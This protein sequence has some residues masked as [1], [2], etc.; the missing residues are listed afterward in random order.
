MAGNEANAR[1]HLRIHGRVQ[2]VAF[3]AY[4]IDEAVRLRVKGWVRNCPDGSVELI[5]EGNR[6][7]VDELVSWCRHGAPSARVDHIDVESEDFKA[8]FRDFRVRR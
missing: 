8:E 6:K 2:G 3:R 7:D 5:A 1:V 4:A